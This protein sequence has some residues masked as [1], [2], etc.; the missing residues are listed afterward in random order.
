[1]RTVAY[2]LAENCQVVKNELPPNYIV[3]YTFVDIHPEGN[4]SESE[5][6]FASEEDFNQ[7]LIVNNSEDNYQQWKN[8]KDA[9]DTAKSLEIAIIM[10]AGKAARDEQ[11]EVYKL[12]FEAF[13]KWKESK[14]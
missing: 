8:A 5:W 12:E 14:I 1:M 11:E 7:L 13:K 6:E 4:L 10:R 2:K 3:E 9:A